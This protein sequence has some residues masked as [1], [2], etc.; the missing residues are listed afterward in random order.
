MFLECE[1]QE[2]KICNCSEEYSEIYIKIRAE[3]LDY[4]MVMRETLERTISCKIIKIKKD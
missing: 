3:G 1:N 4:K 2:K